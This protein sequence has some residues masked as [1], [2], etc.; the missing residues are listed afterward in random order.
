M[1]HYML[2]RIRDD[3]PVRMLGDQPRSLPAF[4]LA[5]SFRKTRRKKKEKGD[6][7]LFRRS[8]ALA[9]STESEK[10]ECPLFWLLW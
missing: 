4:G 3:E 8:A 5:N 7:L 1:H 2:Q 9:V 10:D 6:I